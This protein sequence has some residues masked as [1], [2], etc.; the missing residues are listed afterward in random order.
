MSEVGVASAQVAD[1]LGRM[2]SGFRAFYRAHFDE[3]TPDERTDAESYIYRLEDLRERFAG[4]AIQEEL[5]SVAPQLSELSRVTGQA[6]QAVRTLT[7]IEDVT[8]IVC[9]VLAAAE[10]ASSG[11]LGG[12]VDKLADLADLLPT[13][14]DAAS[15]TATAHG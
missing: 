8:K 13:K 9:G 3:L 15:D 6:D 10:C 11:D 14:P 5:D 4:D 7:R 2:A 1:T 12:T